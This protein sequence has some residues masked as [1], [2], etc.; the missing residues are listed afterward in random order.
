M[1]FNGNLKVEVKS[2]LGRGKANA[3]TGKGLAKILGYPNDRLI[4]LAIRGMI[5]DGVPIASSVNPPFGYYIA[6]TP[7]EVNEYLRVLRSRLIQDAYRR[8]DFKMA[9]REILDPYQMILV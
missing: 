5:A 6:R 2:L 9:A 8:R 7:E 4:R 3:I 1:K